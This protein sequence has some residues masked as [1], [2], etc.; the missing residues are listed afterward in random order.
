MYILQAVQSKW[1]LITCIFFDQIPN[2]MFPFHF[3]YY[4]LS[5]TLPSQLSCKIANLHP[6]DGYVMPQTAITCHLRAPGLI[7]GQ[8]MRIYVGKNA[9]MTFFVP[10]FWVS[11]VNMFPPEL[12]VFLRRR[13]II[14]AIDCVLKNKLK[15]HKDNKQERRIL[16]FYLSVMHKILG[17][18]KQLGIRIKTNKLGYKQINQDT[19]KQIRMQTNKLGCKN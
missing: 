15:T 16:K 11:S 5:I 6:D 3:R 19:N 7:S 17:T 12:R 1:T 14:S 4:C 8:F 9:N 10:V 18:V 2:Y 13:Y